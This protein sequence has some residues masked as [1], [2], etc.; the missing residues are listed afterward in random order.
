ML[1]LAVYLKDFKQIDIMPIALVIL[2]NQFSLKQYNTKTV[3]TQCNKQ[4]VQLPFAKKMLSLR[5]QF[6]K[7]CQV[8][9]NF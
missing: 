8:L 3:F 5:L 9:K 6:K 1:K 7:N 4:L 2:P